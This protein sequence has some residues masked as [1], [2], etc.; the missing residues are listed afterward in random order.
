M[1]ITEMT[2]IELKALV[3]DNFAKIEHLRG[4]SVKINDLIAQ[5]AKGVADELRDRTGK[6]EDEDK[7]STSE[8]Q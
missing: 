8:D 4:M 5:K 1:D 2:I 6:G 7:E 3:Y